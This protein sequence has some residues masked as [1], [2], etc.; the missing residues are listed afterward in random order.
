MSTAD[1]NLKR[2]KSNLKRCG[3]PRNVHLVVYK[4]SNHWKGSRGWYRI[5]CLR[6]MR[7]AKRRLTPALGINTF[8]FRVK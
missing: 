8:R 7:N 1:N 6:V 4:P 2:L 5:Q 3:F